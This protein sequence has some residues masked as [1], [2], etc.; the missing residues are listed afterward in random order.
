MRQDYLASMGHE[1]YQSLN[2]S[3]ICLPHLTPT[4]S[5]GQFASK[6]LIDHKLKKKIDG[7]HFIF[8]GFMT[9][10]SVVRGKSWDSG[11]CSSLERETETE[12][13]RESESE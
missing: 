6:V 2:D 4:E 7:E 11:C 13:E 12:R 1:I 3:F 5:V 8:R 9:T 10:C